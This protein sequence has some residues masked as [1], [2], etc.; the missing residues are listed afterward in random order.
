M[1]DVS[2]SAPAANSP[3]V[4]HPAFELLGRYRSIFGVAWKHRQELA[5]PRRLA[6]EIAFLPAGLSLQ[7]TPVH[8]A[9]RRLAFTLIA[10]F[11]IA[12]A[13]SILGHVD[14]VAVAPGRIEVSE[15]SKVIQPLERS[16]V[17]RVLVKDGDRVHTGQALV[18]LDPTSASADKSTVDEQLKAAQSEELR[19]RVLQQA[20][21]KAERRGSNSAP[22]LSEKA[23]P[24]T[25]TKDD[26]DTAQ[27]QLTAEWSDV[28]AKLAKLSAEIARR[29]AEIAT[30][31]AMVGKLETTLPIVR[32]READFR[33]L[34]E[35]GFMSS[36]ANQDRTRERIELER[37]L[38]TQRARLFETKATLQESDNTRLAYLAETRRAL[39]EREASAALKRSQGIQDQ[40]KA[41]QRERLTTLTAPVSGTVQQLATHTEGGVVTEAQPIMVIVPEDASV[42]A[43]VTLENKDIGFVNVGDEAEIKM[44]TF[45][46]TRYGT[47]KAKVLRLTADAVSDEKRGAIFPITLS[48]NRHTI[49]VDGKLLK[50]SPGMNVSA[51]IKTGHRRIIEFL[52][53]PVQQ[54]RGESL[55]E[56]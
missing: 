41:T 30:V 9:P 51:E 40:T 33:Q 32:Q 47:V 26:L 34:A 20:L 52:L 12:L 7:D 27:A 25:W 42:T 16:V 18:E 35:Q 31:Q 11:L 38:A 37:D 56:R 39:R 49:N 48:L 43:E 55:R 8:P 50:L 54:A 36:H 21:L 4:R 53:D 6:D 28:T 44:E 23:V 22:A 3:N 14:I 13:W 2:T 1:S 5:G 46:Y 29:Q 15:R 19:T 10:L 17:K 45:P 24:S